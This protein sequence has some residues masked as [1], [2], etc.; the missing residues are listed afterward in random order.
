MF[1][2][3]TSRE[4]SV[5]ASCSTQFGFG[6]DS[7]IL[8]LEDHHFN[9]VLVI[10]NP[11]DCVRT[12]LFANFK[13]FY[14]QQHFL[15]LTCGMVASALVS[16]HWTSLWQIEFS[17]SQLRQTVWIRTMLHFIMNYQLLTQ[18]PHMR[19]VNCSVPC[20]STMPSKASA[21]AWERVMLYTCWRHQGMAIQ[22][23]SKGNLWES[24]AS[25][26]K[27]QHSCPWKRPQQRT[28]NGAPRNKPCHCHSHR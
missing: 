2:V 28:T 12:V 26:C 19:L 18:R 6:E 17:S 25:E 24:L 20:R 11:I 16:R 23:N 22:Y 27:P 4:V 9:K 3:D 5:F 21:W 13:P 1:L 14:L 10:S 15:N 7:T 8:N